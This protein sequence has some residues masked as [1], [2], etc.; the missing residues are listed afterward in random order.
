[1]GAHADADDRD[2]GDLVAADDVARL[3]VLAYG[4][5]DLL[6]FLVVVAM[7]GEREIGQAIGPRIW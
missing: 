7:N 1:V 6:R 5:E 4:F 3:D 2:L